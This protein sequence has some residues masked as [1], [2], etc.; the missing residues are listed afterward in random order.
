MGTPVSKPLYAFVVLGAE[1]PHLS[2]GGVKSWCDRSPGI[3]SVP[4]CLEI[5]DGRLLTPLLPLP[6][7]WRRLW[8]TLKCSRG[9]R[10]VTAPVLV[11]LMSWRDVRGSKMRCPLL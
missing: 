7:L 11:E 5:L 9:Q 2:A 3:Q 10:T 8:R 6:Q 4:N 1:G